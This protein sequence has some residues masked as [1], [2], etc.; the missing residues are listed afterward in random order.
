MSHCLLK[1]NV[2]SIN[3]RDT[4]RNM[5]SGS[6][7]HLQYFSMKKVFRTTKYF[8]KILSQIDLFCFFTGRII[9][10]TTILVPVNDFSNPK[11]NTVKILKKCVYSRYVNS[12]GCILS[13]HTCSSMLSQV[14]SVNPY[15]ITEA[16]FTPTCQIESAQ[17]SSEIFLKCK[18]GKWHIPLYC[19]LWKNK[20]CLHKLHRAKTNCILLAKVSKIIC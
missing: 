4:W 8:K 3:S 6:N 16:D 18:F 15:R 13:W 14:N 11:T 12:T 5:C 20:F 19:R 2:T 1:W 7:H 17:L 10:T 9:I